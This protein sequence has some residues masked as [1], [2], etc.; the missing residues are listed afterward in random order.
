MYSGT[1]HA[2]VSGYS[3]F[4]QVLV[5]ALTSFNQKG[6]YDIGTETWKNIFAHDIL[7]PNV[8]KIWYLFI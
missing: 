3:L 1:T 4:P 7:I 6:W 5:H 8:T 2:A